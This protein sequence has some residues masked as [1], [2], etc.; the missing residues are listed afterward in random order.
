VGDNV[1]PVVVVVLVVVLVAL[2]K[3]FFIP[4]PSVSLEI[5]QIRKWT[6]LVVWFQYCEA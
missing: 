6:F 1:V 2:S 5:L 3:V 4:D